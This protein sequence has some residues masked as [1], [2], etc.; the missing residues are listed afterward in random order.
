MILYFLNGLSRLINPVE[1]TNIAKSF[2]Y[3]NGLIGD[4]QSVIPAIGA[5]VC[6]A[7]GY[8]DSCIWIGFPAHINVQKND[9]EM[10][11]GEVRSILRKPI[12]IYMIYELVALRMVRPTIDI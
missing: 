11:L 4:M 10:L 1:K 7:H 3:G 2:G 5:L 12:I 6:L 8:A 9:L